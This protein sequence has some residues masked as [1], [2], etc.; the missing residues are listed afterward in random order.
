MEMYSFLG[1]DNTKPIYTCSCCGQ[2]YDELPLCF[3]ANYPEYYYSVPAN[4][5]ETRIELHES[6]CVVDDQYFFHRGRLTIPITDY[7]EDLIFNVWTTISKDNFNKRMNLWSDSNRTKEEPYFGWLQTSV[8]SYGDIINLKTISIEQEVGFIPEIIII[9]EGH[10]LTLDQENG[11]SYQKAVEIV[12][13]IIRLQH[14][15]D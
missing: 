8:P 13:S 9:E 10:S 5:R 4:E 3:G 12:D 15:A 11:I 2:V 7:H 6:L 14:K 1:E